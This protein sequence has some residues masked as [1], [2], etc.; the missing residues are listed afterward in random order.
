MGLLEK[1]RIRLSSASTGFELG[2]WLSLA[3]GKKE[4]QARAEL[5]QA[6]NQLEFGFDQTY[7]W[8]IKLTAHS[9]NELV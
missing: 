4:K 1:W 2:L 7:I 3:K 9:S 8:W 6:Q 5:G